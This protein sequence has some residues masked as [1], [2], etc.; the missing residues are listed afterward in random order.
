MLEELWSSEAQVQD[1]ASGGE[2]SENNKEDEAQKCELLGRKLI[3]VW[4]EE[5]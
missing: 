1:T 3:E 2:V 4:K 5:N